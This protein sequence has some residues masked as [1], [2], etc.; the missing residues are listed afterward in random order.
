MTIKFGLFCVPCLTDD[1]L[2]CGG[3]AGP[4]YIHHCI[5]STEERFPRNSEAFASEFLGNLKEMFLC[6]W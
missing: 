1:D 3:R 6:C 2:L 5:C 4:C